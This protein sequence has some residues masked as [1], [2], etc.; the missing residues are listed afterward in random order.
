MAVKAK[1]EDKV[2]VKKEW[3]DKKS[4][5]IVDVSAVMRSNFIKLQSE[6]EALFKG[7]FARQPLSYEVNGEE[8]N[9]SA[10]Y[11]LFRLFS[12]FGLDH[13]YV[14]CFDTPNNLLKKIDENYKAN[15]VKMGSEYFDQVNTCYKILEES[16]YRVLAESGF[17]ADHMVHQAVD[18]NYKFYDV[19]GVITNDHDLSCLVDEKVSWLNVLKTRPDITI[20]NY[21]EINKC[22]YNS[23]LLKKATVG[24]KSD[25]IAG[26]RNF[27]EKKFFKF[28]DEEGLYGTD[29][30]GNEEDII[31]NA[32]T[33]TDD[34]KEQAL[35][36]LDLI[37]PYEVSVDAR[38][39]TEINKM[40]I[41]VFLK[42]YGMNSLVKLFE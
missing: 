2:K 37:Y 4:L 7:K 33:L 32:V 19:I 42:K 20:D 30:Y 28:I 6:G 35:A 31:K 26:I 41:K 3:K 8:M 16:G 29:I 24:D 17:E 9:T 14:F 13:D 34:Q 25:N 40:V 27:G 23:I 39:K 10:M 22:P 12:T 1:A 5:L 21:P 15:R 18:D 38:A 36:A 11:G